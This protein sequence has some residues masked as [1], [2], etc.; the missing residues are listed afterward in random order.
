M[1]PHR[2]LRLDL[3]YDG[4]R[5][6]G[7]QRQPNAATLQGTIEAALLRLTGHPVIL[8]GSGRTDAG[9]HARHQVANFRTTSAIPLRAFVQGLNSMLPPDIAVLSV[10]EVPPD[11]HARKAALKK[12]YEY[13]IINR[14]VRSPLERH[15]AWHLASPLDLA[16]LQAAAR[17]LPGEHDFAAF[18]ASGSSV[19]T[20][21]RRVFEAVWRQD[22]EHFTFTITATGFLRGMVRS[23]VGTMVQIGQHRRPPEDLQ[24]LLDHPDRRRTGPT[25]PAQGLVLV[26]VAY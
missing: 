23:L 14:P 25:A 3:E 18:Q 15:F 17:F 16:A 11:F 21:R 4:T 9:V 12:T 5:Y 1:G 19:K 22:R 20:T 8:I 2:N 6:H 10:H 13:H 7:W 26:Q 24:A